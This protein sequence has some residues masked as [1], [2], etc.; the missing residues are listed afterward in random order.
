MFAFMPDSERLAVSERGAA[1]AQVALSL[2]SSR[3]IYLYRVA[4]LLNTD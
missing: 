1:P 3:S 4:D 2:Y